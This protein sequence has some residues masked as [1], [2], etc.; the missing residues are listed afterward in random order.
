LLQGKTDDTY[1]KTLLPRGAAAPIVNVCPIK[2]TGTHHGHEE[3]RKISLRESQVL[4]RNRRGKRVIG[5]RQR[6]QSSLRMWAGYETDVLK[7]FPAPFELLLNLG[8]NTRSFTII[9]IA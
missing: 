9:G 7:E 4:L 5:C 1:G 6:A 2:V 3:K 8:A